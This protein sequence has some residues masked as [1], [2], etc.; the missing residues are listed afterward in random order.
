MNKGILLSIAIGGLAAGTVAIGTAD[1]A[2]ITGSL[3]FSDGGLTLP[4][5]PTTSIVSGLTT[6]TQATP[7]VTSCTGDFTGCGIPNTAGTIALAGPFGGTVY[8]TTVGALTYTFTLSGVSNVS[9]TPLAPSGD[10]LVDGLDFNIAG[11]VDDGP[12]GADPTA[13]SGLWTGNGS[14]V[15]DTGPATCTETPTGSWSVS[16]S[17]LGVPE[18]IPEPAS[19]ALLGVGLLGLGLLRRASRRN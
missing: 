18:R 6:I 1:A 3:S 15:G 11:T 19:A 8:S 14:C 12:G 10:I 17:A 2:F 16:I 4:P 7:A 5:V 9:P 13:F